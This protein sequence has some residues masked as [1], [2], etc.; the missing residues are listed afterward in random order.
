MPWVPCLNRTTVFALGVFTTLPTLTW[1]YN[2]LSWVW[3]QAI[4]PAKFLVWGPELCRAAPHWVPWSE[5]K[6]AKPVVGTQLGLQR[7]ELR[8]ECMLC[9]EA[10]P[11]SLTQLDSEGLSPTDYPALPRDETRVGAPTQWPWCWG[12]GAVAGTHSCSPFSNGGLSRDPSVWCHV[13][14]GNVI[15][16]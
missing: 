1:G 16:V 15:T 2:F 3:D 11:Y 4:V 10:F 8:S 7:E 14:L 5:S 12:C 6:W 9:W 13:G